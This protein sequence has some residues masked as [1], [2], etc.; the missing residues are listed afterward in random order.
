MIGSNAMVNGK[1]G[2][3]SIEDLGLAFVRGGCWV[4]VPGRLQNLEWESIDGRRIVKKLV[5]RG[6]VETVMDIAIERVNRR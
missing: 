3:V 6:L 2:V 1:P 5:N 4:K